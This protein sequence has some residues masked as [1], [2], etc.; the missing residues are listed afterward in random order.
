MRK[1][2]ASL[3]LAFLFLLTDVART[4]KKEKRERK[5]VWEKSVREQDRMLGLEERKRIPVLAS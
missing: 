3:L 4:L 5:R 1:K 2:K